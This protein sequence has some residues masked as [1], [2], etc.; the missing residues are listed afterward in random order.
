VAGR[1]KDSSLEGSSVFLILAGERADL[2]FSS[3]GRAYFGI[4][5][6]IFT[7]LRKVDLFFEGRTRFIARAILSFLTKNLGFASVPKFET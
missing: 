6:Y 1:V 4:F 3:K 2:G 5:Y 7:D